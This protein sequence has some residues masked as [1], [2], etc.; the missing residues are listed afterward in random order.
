MI[1]LFWS[2]SI[3]S[4]AS[5]EKIQDSVSLA[6]RCCLLSPTQRIGVSPWAWAALSRWLTVWSVSP[7]NWRRSLCP[8]ITYLMPSSVKFLYRYFVSSILLSSV[9][10]SIIL[11]SKI[12][13]LLFIRNTLFSPEPIKSECLVVCCIFI[14]QKFEKITGKYINFIRYTIIV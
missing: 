11:V 4:A 8:T 5:C 1:K 13:I 14:F 2:T 10:E 12:R 6:S 3:R 9:Y 7:K